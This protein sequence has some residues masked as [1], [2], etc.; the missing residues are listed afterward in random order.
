MQYL[1]DIPSAGPWESNSRLSSVSLALPGVWQLVRHLRF[2]HPRLTKLSS[3]SRLLDIMAA[4][5]EYG[6]IPKI[7][8]IGPLRSSESFEFYEPKD[9]HRLLS[10]CVS[11]RHIRIISFLMDGTLPE[12]CKWTLIQSLKSL[13]ASIRTLDVIELSGTTTDVQDIVWGGADRLETLSL[14]RILLGP[15]PISPTLRMIPTIQ[16]IIVEFDEIE[17]ES[18][19]TVSFLEIVAPKFPCIQHIELRAYSYGNSLDALQRLANAYSAI[20]KWLSFTDL[21]GE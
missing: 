12:D 19:C 10:L 4:H 3:V 21:A 5:P 9:I 6:F 11:L 8:T 1:H 2:E 14:R 16:K 13:S 20:V 17:R 15:G 18:N 7:I